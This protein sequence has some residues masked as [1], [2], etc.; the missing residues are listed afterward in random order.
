M[1]TTCS[2]LG[3]SMYWTGNS[4]N[5]LLSHCGLVELRI[6]ASYK[7]LPVLISLVEVKVK[8]ISWLLLGAIGDMYFDI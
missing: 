6:R 5:N 4:M 7:D 8:E 2:K 1:H 3:I